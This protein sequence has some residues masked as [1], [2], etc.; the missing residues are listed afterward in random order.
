VSLNSATIR[1]DLDLPVPTPQSVFDSLFDLPRGGLP[2]PQAE[3]QVQVRKSCDGDVMS[4]K[5]GMRKGMRMI[6]EGQHRVVDVPASRTHPGHL[7]SA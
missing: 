5:E 3:L 6:D 4:D 1:I 2:C 7:Q